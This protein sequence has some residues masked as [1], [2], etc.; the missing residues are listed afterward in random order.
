MASD[1]RRNCCDLEEAKKIL[2]LMLVTPE[3]RRKG[4]LAIQLIGQYRSLD[5]SDCCNLL[6]YMAD[7]HASDLLRSLERSFNSVFEKIAA[8]DGGVKFLLNLRA[9]LLTCLKR[10]DLSESEKTKLHQMSSVLKTLFSKWFSVSSLSLDRVTLDSPRQLL[11]RVGALESVHPV[12]NHAELEARVGKYRRCFVFTHPSV[13]GEPLVIFHVA[14]TKDISSS[15]SDLIAKDADRMS[16]TQE[17]EKPEMIKAVTFY[18]I[19]STQPG[20][21]GLGL[22]SDMIK[23]ALA[24]LVAEFPSLQTFATLSPIP[25]F[26][27]WLLN[28]LTKAMDSKEEVVT[29]EEAALIEANLGGGDPHLLLLNILKDITHPPES[30]VLTLSSLL[31]TKLRSIVCRL[32][33]RYLCLEKKDCSALNPVANFHLRNGATIWRLNWMADASLDG[34]DAS[35]GLMV[36]YRYF[37]DRYLVKN[38]N[39]NSFSCFPD[40]IRTVLPTEAST[41]LTLILK[42][43]IY[44]NKANNMILCELIVVF[45][46][47]C[48]SIFWS[49]T[50]SNKIQQISAISRF[51]LCLT[52]DSGRNKIKVI[53]Y[54]LCIIYATV[55]LLFSLLLSFCRYL[56]RRLCLEGGIRCFSP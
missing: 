13:P 26:K 32:A 17:E 18:S 40:W 35:F 28:L 38:P 36:N 4:D 20:L 51:S 11:E 23:G 5:A 48:K 47:S 31:L 27:S 52:S 29:V 37:L 44:L 10:G 53:G 21:A 49:S 14:L 55:K 8:S 33:A 30:G 16:Q 2:Q 22:A 42:F 6:L 46:F 50:M 39:H 25:G 19:S 45:I 12:R 24:R 7:Y 1:L 54:A 56:Q 9:D 3:D 34:V 41:P 15:L 43:P